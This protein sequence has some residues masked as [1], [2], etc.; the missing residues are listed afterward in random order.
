MSA[1]SSTDGAT[2]VEVPVINTVD[3]LVAPTAAAARPE[4]PRRAAED[5]AAEDRRREDLWCLP[6]MGA[7]PKDMPSGGR[8]L[9][10]PPDRQTL[11][12]RRSWDHHQ[13]GR[14]S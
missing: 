6:A 11:T 14:A 9:A 8:C 7:S 4:P 1:T 13:C 5:R 3:R 10:S 12:R 2:A